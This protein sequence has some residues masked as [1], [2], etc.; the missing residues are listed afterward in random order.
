MKP[1]QWVIAGVGVG[2][3]VTFLLF[4]EPSS[5][6]ETG[7]DDVEDAA[8]KA[9]RWGTQ[10]RFGGSVDSIVGRVKEGVGRVTGDDDLAG[11]GVVDR[12]VGAVKDTAGK[13]GHAVGETIHDL[14]R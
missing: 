1:I 8:S 11:E 10:K 13:W 7:Y 6:H 12:A 5:Q 9:W 3:A 4:Y 2:A 14:N